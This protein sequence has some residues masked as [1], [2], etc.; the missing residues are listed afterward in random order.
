MM[1]PWLILIPFIAGLLCWQ[2]ERINAALPRWIALLSMLLVL[3][4]SL[5]LWS[6]GNLSLAPLPGVA[7][8]WTSE[9]QLP[10]IPSFGISFHLAMDGLGVLMVALTGLLGVFSILGAWKE[11]HSRTGLFH[12]NLL[13]LLGAVIGIFTAVDMFLFFF[14]WEVM[15]V[16]TFFLIALWGH[17]GSDRRRHVNAAVKFFIYTQVSG[18]LMLAAILG[19][20]LVHYNATST[21]TFDYGELLGTPFSGATGMVLMLGFFIAFAVKF[22]AMP[23][24][25]WMPDT[26][27]EGPTSGAVDLSGILLKTGAFGIIRFAIPLFP[28]ASSEFAM[29]AMILGVIGIIYGALVAFSQ[30]DIKRLVSWSNVSHMGFVLVALYSGSVIAMQGAV[31]LMIASGLTTGGL[32]LI[33]GQLYHRASTRDLRQMGG[34]WG[35]IHYLPGMSMFFAIAALGLPGTINFAGEFLILVGTFQDHPWIAAI[36]TIGMVLGSVYAL[37]MI[38]RAYFGK[39]ASAS[40]ASSPLPG[41]DRREL[42]MMTCLAVLVVLLGLYPQP[43]LDASSATMSGVHQWFQH[44]SSQPVSAR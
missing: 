21:L 20:V 28:D 16:P 27:A 37:I 19:L 24:H 30:T 39:P 23:L 18:L 41:L 4:L 43:M 44:A 38:H 15:L 9:F 11:N 13:W 32:C 8:S 12:L 2:A 1:L 42:G 10:W 31:V 3:V 6:T 14:F 7:P 29:I 5:T 36:S 26:Q 35:R 17:Q 22:P 40:D 34:L 25:A 33:C